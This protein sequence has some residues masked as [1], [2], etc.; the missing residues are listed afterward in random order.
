[1]DLPLPVARDG[2]KQGGM[3]LPS[4]VVSVALNQPL[5]AHEAPHRA[6]IDD[7]LQRAALSWG[8]L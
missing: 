1:M 6:A 4:R 5:G 8:I 3:R 2:A 7:E